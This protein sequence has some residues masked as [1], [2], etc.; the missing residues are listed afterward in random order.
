VA[1]GAPSWATWPEAPAVVAYPPHLRRT[2]AIALVVGTVLFAINQLDVVFRG[3]AT[4]VVWLKVGLTYLVPFC[5]SNL[6]I[7]IASRRPRA[8]WPTPPTTPRH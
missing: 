8:R 5:V 3:E 4:G 7:L 2:V 1:D 6:G